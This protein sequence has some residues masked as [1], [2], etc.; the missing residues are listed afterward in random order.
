MMEDGYRATSTTAPL[1]RNRNYRLLW[2]SQVLSE[3][4]SN[5]S[6]IAFPLLVLAI[7]G[8][9]GASGLVLTSMATAQLVAG[10]PMG[11]LA[12]RWNRKKIMLGCEA[13]RVIAAAY[14]VAVLLWSEASVAQLVVVGVVMS[15]C[16]ALFEP[17]EDACLPNVVPI[18]QLPTAVAM[19]SARSFL[20]QLSGTAAGGFFFALGRFVP[21]AADLLTHVVS[22]FV[23]LFLKVPSREVQPAPVGHLGHE[24]LV[25]LRWVWQNRPIRVIAMCAVGLNLF[26]TAYFIVIILLAQARGVPSGEI[27][28]MAAMLGVGGFLGTLVAP[29]VQRRVSPYQSIIGVFWVLTILTPLGVFIHSGYLMGAIFAAIAFLTPTANTT[30]AT[31]GLLLTPDELRGRFSGVMGAVTGVAAAAGPAL[32]GLLLEVVTASQAVLLCTAGIGVVT[33]LTTWSPTLRSFPRF[34]AGEEPPLAIHGAEHRVER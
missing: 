9:P 7:T 22:F 32:G 17:A 19:N 31:Y 12:D 15:L 26:F 24:M 6:A 2:G 16:G 34:Q 10:L 18:D 25:G 1:S 11:A 3:F 33:L 28:I 4:G 13:A 30:I 21:F 8:S 20:G 5:A 23:L 29:Y 14:L 27:G